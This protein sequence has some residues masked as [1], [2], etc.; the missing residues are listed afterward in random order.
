MLLVMGAI[1]PASPSV[2]YKWW[3]DVEYNAQS[4]RLGRL[5]TTFT[6]LKVL[7]EYCDMNHHMSSTENQMRET[8]YHYSLS[9]LLLS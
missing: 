1:G 3:L 4:R 8:G 5:A 7:Y 9:E 2:C 6:A